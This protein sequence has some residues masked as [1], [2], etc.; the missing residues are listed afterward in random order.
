MIAVHVKVLEI[1][2]GRNNVPS[3]DTGIRFLTSAK[4]YPLLKR[5]L[6]FFTITTTAP[7]MSSRFSCCGTKP[8]RKAPTSAAVI[9]GTDCCD[10]GAGSEGL[11]C[12]AGLGTCDQAARQRTAVAH[13][14]AERRKQSGFMITGM[15]PYCGKLLNFRR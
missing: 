7:A 11:T 4:P 6:P 10:I 5:T 1:E 8:S 9:S 12:G 13:T 2:P 3:G 14:R 15:L